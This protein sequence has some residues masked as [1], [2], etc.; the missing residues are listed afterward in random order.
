MSDLILSEPLASEIRREAAAH[1]VN[2]DFLIKEALRHYHFKTQKQKISAETAWWRSRPP[3]VRASYHD[4]Y[5]AIHNQQVVD[6]DPVEE[7][8]RQRIR[9]RYEKTAVLITPAAGQSELHI[10][11]TRWDRL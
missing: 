7:N 2:V 9:A 6:H 3:E 8:L 4:E 5:V 10:T 11:S 1:G